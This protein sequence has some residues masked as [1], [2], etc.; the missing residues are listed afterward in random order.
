VT[1]QPFLHPWSLAFPSD[2]KTLLGANRRI[3]SSMRHL[4]TPAAY[5]VRP[6]TSKE[7]N[8]G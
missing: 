8:D 6:A 4:E 5:T 1:S 2:G 3:A 7:N